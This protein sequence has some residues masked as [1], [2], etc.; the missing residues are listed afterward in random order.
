MERCVEMIQAKVNSAAK[1]KK[2]SA[3]LGGCVKQLII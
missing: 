2:A 3:S 1:T